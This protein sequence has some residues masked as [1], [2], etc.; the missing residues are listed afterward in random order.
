[1]ENTLITD[2]IKRDLMPDTL[3][4]DVYYVAND[5]FVQRQLTVTDEIAELAR[6]MVPWK[7]QLSRLMAEGD[8][9]A[10][11]AKKLKKSQKLVGKAQDEAPVVRLISYWQHLSWL[12]DG[13]NELQR[14]NML[15]RIAVDNEIEDPD[16]ARKSI[17]ELNNMA[18]P[19][20]GSNGGQVI[21]IVIN[22][23]VLERGVL[24]G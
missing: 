5:K 6:Q 8:N 9:Q 11:C 3:Q 18:N 4:N 20:N 17:S 21:Q 10:Q 12:Q 19:K 2:E 24:D 1:M 23:E 15:W 22:N 7:A 14:K 16:V 13:P